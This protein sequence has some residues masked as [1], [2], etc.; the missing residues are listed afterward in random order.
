M[1]DAG[2]ERRNRILQLLQFG[3]H[4]RGHQIGARAQRLAELDEGRPEL[5]QRE[6]DATGP[7]GLGLCTT[8][9]GRQ[10]PAAGANRRPEMQRPYRLIETVLDEDRDDLGV[11]AR[12][13]D[14]RHARVTD[15][16]GRFIREIRHGA[17]PQSTRGDRERLFEQL[18][19]A[20]DGVD[21]LRDRV[22]RRRHSMLRFDGTQI[23]RKCVITI[24]VAEPS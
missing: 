6:P 22:G 23:S 9:D 10:Q 2:I 8:A 13:S 16:D 12:V 20:A 17:H 11:P 18:V 15:G 4:I 21:E 14:P 3:Q 7:A 1:R 24:D 5:F 19:A